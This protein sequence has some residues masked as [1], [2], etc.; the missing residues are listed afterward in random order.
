MSGTTSSRTLQSSGLI[1]SPNHLSHSGL[2]IRYTISPTYL[3][4]IECQSSHKVHLSP[5]WKML[6]SRFRMCSKVKCICSISFEAKESRY[7]SSTIRSIAESCITSPFSIER[8]SVSR[9][10]VRVNSPDSTVISSS[11]GAKEPLT[12]INPSIIHR[13]NMCSA[14]SSCHLHVRATTMSISPFYE[15]RLVAGSNP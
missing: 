12:I 15:V 2:G 9:C 13:V 11:S 1:H 5:L 8:V 4:Q 7:N 14:S 10:L 6:Q 3:T